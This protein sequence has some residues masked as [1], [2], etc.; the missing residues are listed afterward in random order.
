MADPKI[1]P[2]WFCQGTAY[3]LIKTNEIANAKNYRPITSLP[4]S[5]KLLTYVNMEDHNIFPIKQKGC[6]KG[7]Y[8]CKDQLLVNKIILENAKTKE[9]HMST[10]WID[11]KKAFD[12]VPHSWILRYLETFKV[13]PTLINL[14]RTSMKLW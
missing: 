7:S 1:T 10:A 11:Y 8:G 13:S 2:K 3:L 5:Y 9:K 4:T 14:H 12:S 6:R